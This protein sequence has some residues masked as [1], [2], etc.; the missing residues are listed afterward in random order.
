MKDKIAYDKKII[1]LIIR[2]SYAELDWALPVLQELKKN[3]K[4]YTYFNSKEAFENIR[5]SKFFFSQ[6]KN[7]SDKHYTRKKREAFILRL[8]FFLLKK[9]N[10]IVPVKYL[11]ALDRKINEKLYSKESFCSYFKEEYH[12]KPVIVF[13]PMG[14]KGWETGWIDTYKKENI[15]TVRYPHSTQ[16]HSNYF[17]DKIYKNKNEY[18]ENCIL[19]TGSKHDLPALSNNWNLKNIKIVGYP[20]YEKKW[21]KNYKRIENHNNNIGV[22]L[23]N[24]KKNE[25]DNFKNLIQSILK[26]SNEIIDFKV[27]FKLHPSQ[28]KKDFLN[29]IRDLNYKN[30]EISEDNALSIASKSKVFL[31]YNRSSTILTQYQL[32]LQ[33]LNYGVLKFKMQIIT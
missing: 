23:K 11:W 17:K 22:T 7:F 15:L 5:S 25:F 8:L 21:L 4:I 13:N 18:I 14:E 30:W 32:V 26:I 20:R 1:L 33:Q 9:I 19:L 2:K 3:F 6:W 29:I 12:V 10:F 27:L 31:A 24:Y 16:I 28:R